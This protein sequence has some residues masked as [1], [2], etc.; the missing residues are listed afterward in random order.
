MNTKDRAIKALLAIIGIVGILNVTISP[1]KLG[2]WYQSIESIA[3]LGAAFVA[4]LFYEK[5]GVGRKIVEKQSDY[6]LKF[7]EL[8]RKL[9]VE[10]EFGNAE[11]KGRLFFRPCK[12][13]SY[14]FNDYDEGILVFRSV[15]LGEY[16]KLNEI[17]DS[18]YFPVELKASAAFLSPTALHGIVKEDFDKYMIVGSPEKNDEGDNFVGKQHGVDLKFKHYKHSWKELVNVVEKWLHEKAEKEVKVI[19]WE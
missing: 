11:A 9:L 1:A 4:I 13:W 12:T 2:I 7:A 6:V 5:Y 16:H 17:A 14:D 19:L 8:M 18:L 10:I 15:L 3:T